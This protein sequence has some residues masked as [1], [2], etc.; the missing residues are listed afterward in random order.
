M[1]IKKEDIVVCGWFAIGVIVSLLIVCSEVGWDQAEIID[2]IKVL[3][4]IDILLACWFAGICFSASIRRDQREKEG[5]RRT[6]LN[7]DFDELERRI[8]KLEEER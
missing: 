2:D 8:E 3:M 6:W 7:K 5:L 1:I 4:S